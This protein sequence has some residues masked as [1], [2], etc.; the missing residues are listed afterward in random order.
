MLTRLRISFELILCLMNQQLEAIE[1]TNTL[2][3]ILTAT[4]LVLYTV[5]EFLNTDDLVNLHAI[6]KAT[7]KNEYSNLEAII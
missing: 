3:N 2:V 1:K 6:L 4:K 5:L 7:K